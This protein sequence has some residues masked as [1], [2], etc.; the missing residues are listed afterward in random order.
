MKTISTLALLLFVLYAYSQKTV[1]YDNGYILMGR[2]T[3]ALREFKKMCKDAEVK[4]RW[5]RNESVVTFKRYTY[6]KGGNQLKA[7][8][9]ISKTVL[10]NIS[11][12]GQG[13]TLTSAG[14]AMGSWLMK[15]SEPSVAL[16]IIGP[17]VCI[18]AVPA[19]IILPLKKIQTKSLNNTS[20][21]KYFNELVKRY[22]FRVQ[23]GSMI[24][25]N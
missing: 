22:N 23:Y 2:D 21:D 9:S 16:D 19:G 1:S 8:H 17:L 3:L 6:L 14:I 15:D 11:L 24:R 5:N 10:R 13:A 20:A 4:V 7:G 18:A 12:F 25:R